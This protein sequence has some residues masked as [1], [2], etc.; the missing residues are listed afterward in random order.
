[1]GWV[2]PMVDRDVNTLILG[3]Y[4]GTPQFGDFTLPPLPAGICVATALVCVARVARIE[5]AK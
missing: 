5:P 3:E 2:S 1:M 4:K